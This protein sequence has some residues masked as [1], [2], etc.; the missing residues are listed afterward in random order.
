LQATRQRF[1]LVPHHQAEG[2]AHG[3]R[4]MVGAKR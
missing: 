2:Y 1:L 4:L 3:C